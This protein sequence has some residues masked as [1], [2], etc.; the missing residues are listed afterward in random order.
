MRSTK[1]F[2]KAESDNPWWRATAENRSF[3]PRVTHVFSCVLSLIVSDI[4]T[5]QQPHGYPAFHSK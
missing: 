4:C 2:S 3:V 1:R 5:K